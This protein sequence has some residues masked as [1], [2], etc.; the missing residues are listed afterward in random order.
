[1]EVDFNKITIFIEEIFDVKIIMLKNYD[2]EMLGDG[3][4]HIKGKLRKDKKKR[5]PEYDEVLDVVVEK[6]QLLN[7]S[8]KGTNQY[9]VEL[10]IDPHF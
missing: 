3:K 10:Q 9:P 1:M 8:I 2:R 7:I 4:V 5:K 6:Y